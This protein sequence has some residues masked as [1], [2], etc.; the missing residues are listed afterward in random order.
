MISATSRRNTQCGCQGRTAGRLILVRPPPA[1]ATK[2]RA[3]I[4][5]ARKRGGTAT[6]KQRRAAD[7]LVLLTTFD[8]ARF[9]TEPVTALYRLRWQ[10]ELAFKRL[11]SQLRLADLPAKDPQLARAC[12]LAKLILALLVDRLV[13]EHHRPFRRGPALAR[14]PRGLTYQASS[15]LPIAL[16]PASLLR[17]ISARMPALSAAR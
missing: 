5:K 11:Q 12:I 14:R 6:L 8:A 17:A 15:G 7:W 13:D 4:E 10:I 2:S 16:E 1:S 9:P 3:R